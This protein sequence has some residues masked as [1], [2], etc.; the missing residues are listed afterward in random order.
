MI[1]RKLSVL[2]GGLALLLSC[3]VQALPVTLATGESA[4]FN[5]DLTSEGSA[6]FTNVDVN[7]TVTGPGAGEL[8]GFDFYRELSGVDLAFSFD[9]LTVGS[10]L[11]EDLEA[12]GAADG[13]FSLR[14]RS[15][16]GPIEITELDANGVDAGGL[17]VGVDGTSVPVPATLPLL[18]LGFVGIAYSRRKQVKAVRGRCSALK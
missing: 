10:Y 9:D 6:P 8:F 16:V 15:T 2:F 13:L 18:G 17:P 4:L 12:F 5:F 3:H 7:L 14:V 1:R 11:L